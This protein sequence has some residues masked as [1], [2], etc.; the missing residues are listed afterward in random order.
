M[1]T[2]NKKKTKLSLS[3]QIMIG[4][5]LGFSVGIFFGEYVAFLQI[6]G[7]A[8]IKL[9][10]ITILPY[11]MV[12]MILGIGG[13][14][15]DQAKLMVK[16]T[17]ILILLFWGIS[18]VM[19]L[20]MP[21][22]F[23]QWESAAFFS[24]SIVE[25][26]KEV[27]FLS[28]YIPSN[29]FYSLANNI[30]PAVVLF[31]ILTGVALMGMEKKAT[32]LET[33]ST[34][35][36]ALVRMTGHIVKLTPIGVFAITAAAAGTMT[37]EEFGRL[38]VYLV[39]FNIAAIFLTFWILPM[40]VT[41]VTPFKYRDIIGMT[42]DAL[43]TAFTTGNLF[44]VLTVLTEGCKQIFETYDLKKDKTDTYVDVL[45]PISF[46]LPN[47]GKLLML[48]F[49]LFAAWFSGSTFS[50]MQ[51]PTFV[52]AGLLSF[53]GGVDV[54]MPFMLDL[55]HIP[56]DL[57]QLYVVTGIINGRFATLLAA[58]NLVIFTLLATASLTGVMSINKKKLT[59]YV[60]ISLLLTAG[61]IGATRLYFSIAV[62]NVYIKDQVIAN[63][64]SHV[65]PVSRKVHKN[66]KEALKPVDLSKPTLR[67]IRESG[68]LRVGYHPDH[69]PFSY[70]SQ[71]GELIGFDIDMAQ[72][73]A[74][75]MKVK[76][77]FIPFEFDTMVTQLNVGQFDLI[78]AGVAV[79]T[80]RLEKMTYSA[81]YMEGTLAFIVPDHRRN[82]FASSQ[83][84]KSIS[85]LKIGVPYLADYFF[86]KIKSYLPQAEI[87]AVKSVREFFGANEQNLDALLWGAENGAAWTLLYPKFQVV[88]PVPDVVKLPL[89]YPVGGGDKKFAEFIS[90]WIILKKNGLEYPR[91]YDHWILGKDAVPKQPRWSIIRDVLHWIE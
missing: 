22:S 46:N 53:F 51:Y 28:L 38:Q 1:N 14:T 39:S 71:S 64:Q 85:G 73:L 82:E 40:L 83:A 31:S 69:L 6:I 50:L 79:T 47:T 19:V 4:M 55:M 27:D 57:Y 54:A 75:E 60:I 49:I 90:Q 84:V 36:Q 86:D 87:V 80:T 23:P 30:V 29:P 70:F 13:L 91:L 44:V 65:F 42:R 20:L 11:I 16:K 18:F 37:I 67:R 15:A 5:G 72:L 43:V 45:V 17:G 33:L 56:A 63:M 76:L 34:V 52:F 41:L 74:R 8:F 26:P 81:P 48:L 3:A 62:K 25:S 66:A 32:L 12:S 89:A 9:L 10:Q 2:D 7:N 58:M 88:V 61:L 21:L 77:E 24:S 78:M 35:S 59:N 68:V